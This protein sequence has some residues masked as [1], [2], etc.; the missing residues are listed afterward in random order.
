MGKFSL[1]FPGFFDGGREEGVL[2]SVLLSEE[3]GG[4]REV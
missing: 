2:R 3:R 1:S 4:G